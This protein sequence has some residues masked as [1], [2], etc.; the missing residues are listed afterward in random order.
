MDGTPFACSSTAA[1][2]TISG[3]TSHTFSVTNTDAAQNQTTRTYTWS[4]DTAPPSLTLTAHPAEP[5][6][7][8]APTF[9][10]TAEPGSTV[11]CTLDG[12]PLACTSTTA[13]P[14][15]STQVSHTFAVT[16]TDAAQN[17]TTQTFTW[18]LDTTAPT[19]T[20]DTKPANP[21]NS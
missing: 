20:L 6:K 2:T 14:S 19:L 10:Y 13:S 8:T 16:A 5:S 18:T 21:S 7:D 9:T 17:A 3:D 4:L 11:T 1:T 12:S 15:I